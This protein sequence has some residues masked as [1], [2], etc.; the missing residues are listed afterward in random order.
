MLGLGLG[1]NTSAA[2]AVGG[3][4]NIADVSGIAVWLKYNT[5]QGSITD[6]IQ[7]NDQSS[8]G[9]HASQTVD[10]QEGSFSGGAYVT[11][12]GANDNLDFNTQINLPGSYHVFVVLDLSEQ[13]N[14][15]VLSSSNSSTSFMRLGQGNATTLRLR[16]NTSSNQA[17]ISMSEAF[18]TTKAIFEATRDS[19]GNVTIYKNGTSIGT[20]AS[21]AGTFELNQISAQ[22][23]GLSSAEIHEVVVFTTDLSS[24]DATSIREDIAARN[25]VTL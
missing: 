8:N 15:G 18:G 3:D 13:T 4:F 19:S 21:Q 5:G 6:G 20:A 2:R 7:W 14:E 10:A 17:N 16:H 9:N 23:N 22:S 25:S 24:G 1:C 11:D 12:A